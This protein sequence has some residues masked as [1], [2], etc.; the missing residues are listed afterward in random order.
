MAGAFSS[1][2]SYDSERQ[3][4]IRQELERIETSNP[5]KDVLE[6]IQRTLKA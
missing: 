4:L 5:P 3:A 1:W 6:I 2:K